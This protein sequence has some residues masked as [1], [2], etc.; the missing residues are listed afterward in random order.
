MEALRIANTASARIARVVVHLDY[1]GDGLGVLA[2][3]LALE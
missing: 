2:V 3:K 1:R